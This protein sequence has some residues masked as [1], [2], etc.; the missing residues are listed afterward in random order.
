VRPARFRPLF[1]RAEGASGDGVHVPDN[2][3]HWVQTYNEVTISFALTRQTAATRRRG[4]IDAVNHAL[5]RRGLSPVPYGKSA[6]PDFLKFQ[7]Y[8]LG[9]AV[10]LLR[11]GAPAETPHY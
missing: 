9:K 6:L 2:H 10:S 11:H 3:P 8:R 5:R 7:A 4:A 1:Q